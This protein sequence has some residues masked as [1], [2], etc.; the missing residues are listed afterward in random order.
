MKKPEGGVQQ[1][2]MFSKSQNSF[3]SLLKLWTFIALVAICCFGVAQSDGRRMRCYKCI[4]TTN[5]TGNYRLKGDDCLDPFNT[6]ARNRDAM[7]RCSK[8]A[9]G[10]LKMYR[11]SEKMIPFCLNVTQQLSVTR[12]DEIL[13][14]W[15]ILKP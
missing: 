7:V 13:P 2:A 5:G 6:N 4:S 8:E 3:F 1:Q 10:C 9:V 11:R 14:L 12:F 15:R